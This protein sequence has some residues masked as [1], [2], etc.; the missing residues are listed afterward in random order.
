M[1]KN[2][3]KRPSLREVRAG[4]ATMHRRRG[5]GTPALQ[6]GEIDSLPRSGER[7]LPLPAP[8][9]PVPVYLGTPDRRRRR[10]PVSWRHVAYGA[11]ALATALVFGKAI[12]GG[13]SETPRAEPPPPAARLVPVAASPVP[14]PAASLAGTGPSAAPV[15]QVGTLVIRVAWPD[16]EIAVDGQPVAR[17]GGAVRIPAVTAGSHEVTATSPTQEPFRRQVLVAA[18]TEIEVVVDAPAP[19]AASAASTKV[20]RVDGKRSASPPPRRARRRERDREE[21]PAPRET[22]SAPPPKPASPDGIINPFGKK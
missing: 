17:G 14:V 18:G 8:V 7:G 1:A 3:S 12:L 15:D 11:G 6:S 22:R 13:S 5:E 21:T 9:S 2:P 4:L 10:Q 19:V 20:A 16:A